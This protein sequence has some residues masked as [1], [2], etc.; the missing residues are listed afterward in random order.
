LTVSKWRAFQSAIEDGKGKGIEGVKG[1]E[2]PVGLE[3]GISWRGQRAAG[4]GDAYI[5]PGDFAD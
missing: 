4:H 1:V 5:R 2:L 3:D